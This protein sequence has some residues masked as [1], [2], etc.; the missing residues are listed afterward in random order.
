M[1]LSVDSLRGGGTLLC[2]RGGG[3]GGGGSFL[4]RGRVGGGA[5]FVRVRFLLLCLHLFQVPGRASNF[6][7]G[8]SRH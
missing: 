5:L 4:W 2:G 8:C 3:E 7:L 1:L 6:V